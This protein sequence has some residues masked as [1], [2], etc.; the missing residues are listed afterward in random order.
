M[1]IGCGTAMAA[2]TDVVLGA[3]PF[4][5]TA[6]ETNPW[7]YSISFCYSCIITPTGLATITFN[8]DSVTRSALQLD[9]TNSLTPL[10]VTPFTPIN[11]N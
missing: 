4:G 2:Q 11:F 6:L 5:I 1:E 9:C 7:G 10:A 3:S 8:H